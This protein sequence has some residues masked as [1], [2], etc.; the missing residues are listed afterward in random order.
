MA[1]RIAFLQNNKIVV[2]PSCAN[3]I[4]ELSNFSY[5]KDKKSGLYTEDTTHEFS[6]SLDALG[7]AY[8]DLYTKA[9]LRTLDKSILGL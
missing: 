8:S 3:V 1:A 4:R 2:N 6:H 9:K 5:I 7:Y